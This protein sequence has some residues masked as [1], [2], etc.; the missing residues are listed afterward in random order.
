LADRPFHRLSFGEKKRVAVASALVLEPGLLLLDEPTIGLDPLSV[1][2]LVSFVT[3]AVSGREMSVLWST[4]ELD[5]VP[6]RASRMLYLE[7][8]TVRFDGAITEFASTPE[9]ERWF[10]AD[11]ALRREVNP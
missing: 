7:E 1:Q 4:H 9:G 8:R 2:E 5:R 3:R 10:E 11:R 6:E